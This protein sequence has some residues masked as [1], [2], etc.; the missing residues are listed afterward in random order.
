ME[1]I[2]LDLLRLA[3]ESFHNLMFITFKVTGKIPEKD[4][5][6]WLK[7]ERLLAEM[8]AENAK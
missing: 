7:G 6:H 5:D 2:E 8:E 4:F 1:K 3:V